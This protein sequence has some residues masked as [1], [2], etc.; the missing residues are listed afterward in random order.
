MN[1]VFE[2]SVDEDNDT[3]VILQQPDRIN[4]GNYKCRIGKYFIDSCSYP[5]TCF[6]QLHIRGTATGRDFETVHRYKKFKDV[7][8]EWCRFE[9][10]NLVINGESMFKDLGVM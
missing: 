5:E 3:F 1:N 9:G 8:E 7:I 2:I 4:R 6:Y 10:F